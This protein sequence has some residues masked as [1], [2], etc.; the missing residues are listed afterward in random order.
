[1][2]EATYNPALTTSLDRLRFALGDTDV[3]QPLLP[4]ATYAA[5]LEAQGNDE[6]AAVVALARS[7]VAREAQNPTRVVAA[8]GQT[9]EFGTR[10]AGWQALL[11]ADATAA[12]ASASARGMRIHRPRRADAGEDESEYGRGRW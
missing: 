2:S 4:D 6:T 1:M 9:T 11:A 10:L 3:A 12:A 7:L 8:D 5:V